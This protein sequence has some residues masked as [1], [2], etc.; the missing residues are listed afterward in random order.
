[1]F[2]TKEEVTM[3]QCPCCKAVMLQRTQVRFINLVHK[4]ETLTSRQ[5]SRLLKV[6]CLESICG[7]AHR[8]F[9]HGL[10]LKTVGPKGEYTFSL[11]KLGRETR[12]IYA[13][14]A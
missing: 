3:A 2:K 10:L 12:E 8:L 13:N 14:H 5:I 6:K 4:Y 9:M 11:S 7:R 1:M